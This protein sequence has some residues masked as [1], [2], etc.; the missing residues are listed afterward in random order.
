MIK[1]FEEFVNETN[2]VD[3]GKE[4]IWTSIK[5]K[6]PNDQEKVVVLLGK[7]DTGADYTDELLYKKGEFFDQMG[8]KVD[9]VEFWRRKNYYKEILWR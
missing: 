3:K 7:T 9:N 6:T 1:K 8:R 5:D 4:T 2:C